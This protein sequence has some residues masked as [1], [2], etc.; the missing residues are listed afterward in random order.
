M[1]RVSIFLLIILIMLPIDGLAMIKTKTESKSAGFNRTEIKIDKID[2]FIHDKMKTSK[3]PG[4]SVVIVKNGKEIYKRGFGFADIANEKAVSYETLFELGSTSK[5]FTALAILNLQEQGLI[6]IK[7]SV[8]EYIPWFTMKFK[9]EDAVI[10]I[11]DL[12]HHKSGVPFKTIADIPIANG[13]DAL[14]KTV[15]K[16]VSHELKHNPGEVFEYATINYDVL[17][18]IIQE[19]SGMSYEKYMKQNILLP[20]GLDNTYLFR[21]DNMARGY[22]IGYMRA[23][24]YD[25]PIYRGNT[26]AGYLITNINDMSKWLRIQLGK[27]QHSEYLKGL[28]KKSHI[29]NRSVEPQF[30]GSSYAYGWNVYQKGGGEVSHGGENPNFSSYI[31]FRPEEELGVAVLCNMNS[32]YTKIIGQ[33]IMN[34][35]LGKEYRAVGEDFYRNIDNISII[36]IGAS[37]IFLI[38]TLWYLGR[39][40]TQI[41]KKQRRVEL[42]RKKIIS[43]ILS[44]SFVS[45][46]LYC[47]YLIPKILFMELSWEFIRVWGPESF[48]VGVCLSVLAIIFFYI[49]YSLSMFFP[50]KDDTS[51]F[52]ITSL[53]VL[54][55]LGNALIIFTIN[56]AIGKSQGLEKIF[57]T[58]LFLYF[59]ISITIYVLGQKV[60]RRELITFTNNLIYSKRTQIIRNILK[61]SFENM[62][63][64]EHEKVLSV[65]NNDTE[66]ISNFGNIIITSLTSLV[67]LICCFVYLGIM[68]I[69][70]LLI[71]LLVIVLAAGM[72]YFVGKSANTLWEETRVIQD[73]FFKIINDL[74]Y[75]FKELSLNNLKKKEFLEDAEDRCLEYKQKRTKALVKFSNVIVI[76]ELLFTF[77]IGFVVFVFPIVF[78]EMGTS[79]L[80]SYI[81]VFLYMTGPVNNI[82]NNIPII[83]QMRISWKKLLDLNQRLMSVKNLSSIDEDSSLSKNNIKIYLKNVHYKYE[84]QNG[85]RFTVGPI[86]CD[87]N[88]GEITFITGGNGSGKS[89][90]A[91]LITGLYSPMVGEIKVNGNKV[92][93]EHLSSYYSAV[94]CDFYLFEKL[95]GID[96]GSK[97]KELEKYLKILRIDDKVSIENGRFNT[98]KLSTGQKKRLALLMSYLEDRPVYLFDEW[99]SDQDP[100]FRRFFYTNLLPDLRNNGKC[101]IAITH[102]DRYFHVADKVINMEMGKI[103]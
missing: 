71:S 28:I 54:S 88:A 86:N 20:L 35:M 22:K 68:N 53:S 79:I 94:F 40:I 38:A 73:V 92:K 102:D 36:V 31:T 87:F 50:K 76:G 3:I 16:L 78:K 34:M 100:E 83:L 101:I 5:A 25:A 32:S 17:G 37:I 24:E 60:V 80:R 23:C 42:T 62:E 95:Y 89:T 45:L 48:T 75:G 81:F 4:L 90:L 46:L 77:V 96:H 52:Y 18:L 82:L 44:L 8:T 103:V 66:N 6:N 85:E 39:L 11:E 19:V 2:D 21:Q 14:E 56:M 10:T 74:I 98:T 99:A 27:G 91:K 12:L 57:E 63:S 47:I 41:F 65:L 55:G 64:I 70:G 29:P 33:G 67:T 13:K 26:P 1:K 59:L 49:Y 51:I 93:S 7:D 72:H 43:F 61:T 84:E 30:D 69:F 9:G 15:E 97:S 58:G